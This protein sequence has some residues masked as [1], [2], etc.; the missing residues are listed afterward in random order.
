MKTGVWWLAMTTWNP[1][2]AREMFKNIIV[3]LEKKTL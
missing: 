3:E 2:K 1:T